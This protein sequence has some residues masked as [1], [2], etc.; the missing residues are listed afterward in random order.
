MVAFYQTNTFRLMIIY[1]LTFL[2]DNY[3][4]R[5]GSN[6]R[7]FHTTRVSLNWILKL[8]A[9]FINYLTTRQATLELESSFGSTGAKQEIITSGI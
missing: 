2:R 9:Q 7:Q 3:S 4:V 5:Q 8:Q 6:K 1:Q